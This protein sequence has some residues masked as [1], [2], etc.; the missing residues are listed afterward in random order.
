MTKSSSP[1]NF[2]LYTHLLGGVKG[3]VNAT[4]NIFSFL[5]GLMFTGVGSLSG[6][7]WVTWG[8]CATMAR[9]TAL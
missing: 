5:G 8:W 1:E 6:Q 3:L 9:E 7:H 2:S 4:S